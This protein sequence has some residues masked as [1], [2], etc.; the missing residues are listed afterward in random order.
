MIAQMINFG[1]ETT[2]L[3]RIMAVTLKNKTPLIVPPSIQRRAG[4]SQA[5]RLEFR[6]RGGVITI[7]AK[8]PSAAAEYTP[9]QRRVIDERLAEAKK[10]RTYGPFT[11]SQAT[12]FLR[13][14]IKAR[15][16]RPNKTG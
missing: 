8:P 1:R 2:I 5:D 4:L 10:G 12:R 11:A 13:N 9:E 16:R 14:E 6:A 3:D 15:A 7:T